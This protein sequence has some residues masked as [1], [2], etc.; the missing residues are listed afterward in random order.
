MSSMS[1]HSLIL[2]AF[3]LFSYASAETAKVTFVN[4]SEEPVRVYF[5]ADSAPEDSLG[6]EVGN[7]KPGDSAVI[8]S[9]VGHMFTYVLGDAIEVLI[10]EEPDTVFVIGPKVLL[11]RCTTTA[12]DIT[13]KIIPDWSPHGAARFLRLVREGYYNGC[14]LNR[15]IPKFLTQFGIS[16]DYEARTKWRSGNNIPD[17]PPYKGGVKFEPGFLSYAGSGA[18]SRSNEIFIVMPDTPI[19]QLNFFGTNSWETPFGYVLPEDEHVL[20]GWHSYGDMA[21]W[22]EGPDPQKI[23]LEDGYDYL[24]TVFPDLSYI[25]ECRISPYYD[26]PEREL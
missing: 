16:A 8:N 7:V 21:P 24:K 12:G 11:V 18:D 9:Y 26:E 5:R 3:S 15:V 19:A 17:D 10:V 6:D 14:G 1:L 25:E 23:Y 20:S 2:F 4:V 22:G 13:A